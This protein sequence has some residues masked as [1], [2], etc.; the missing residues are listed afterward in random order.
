MKRL[1]NCPGCGATFTNLQHTPN[2]F[3]QTCANKCDVWY[4]Q[5]FTYSFEDEE[6]DYASFKTEHF[7][8]YAYYNSYYPGHAHIYSRS[9]LKNKGVAN[10]I[11]KLPVD[12]IDIFNL[13]D[14]DK[15]LQTLVVFS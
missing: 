2:W 7:S 10:V 13:D 3:S 9:D 12:R 6:V 1:N 5:N 15:R 14:L 4:N 11:F 8:V